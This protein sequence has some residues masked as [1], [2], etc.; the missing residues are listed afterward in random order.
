MPLLFVSAHNGS[1][2][3]SSLFYCIIVN[4]MPTK[5]PQMVCVECLLEHDSS[6]FLEADDC[7]IDILFFE[8]DS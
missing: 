2:Q 3:N 4:M 6:N 8:L 7:P 5:Y 1:I